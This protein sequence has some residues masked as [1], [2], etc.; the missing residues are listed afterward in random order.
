[1]FLWLWIILFDNSIKSCQNVDQIIVV[2]GFRSLLPYNILL[3]DFKIIVC[4]RT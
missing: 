1:M 2:A 3:L 4:L